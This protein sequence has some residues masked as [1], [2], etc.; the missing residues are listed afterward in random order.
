MPLPHQEQI[1]MTDLAPDTGGRPQA[2]VGVYRT[3]LE[4]RAL[5]RDLAALGNDDH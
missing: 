1:P 5:A 2:V 3:D 4:A